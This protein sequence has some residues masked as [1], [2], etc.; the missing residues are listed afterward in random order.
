MFP[1]IQVD[2]DSRRS[3]SMGTKVKFW[4]EYAGEAHL[5]KYPRLDSGED[6]SEKVAAEIAD[7]LGLPHAEYELAIA[8][9]MSATISRK[10]HPDY[11]ELIT[12]DVLLRELVEDYP[13]PGTISNFKLSKH[14]VSAVLETLVSLKVQLPVRWTPPPGIT[15]APEVF[16]G[17][18]MLDALIGN[19]DRHHEN[20]GVVTDTPQ[21]GSPGVRHLAPTFDHASSLGCHESESSKSARLTTKDRNFTVEKY[22]ERARSRLY[23][24]SAD[25]KPLLTIRAFDLAAEKYQKAAR[26]WLARLAALEVGE[27]VKIMKR[28]P[29]DRI[30]EGS[31]QFASEILRHNRLRLLN[32]LSDLP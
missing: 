20:W 32:L 12:G 24:D 1:I 10:F 2:S 13:T 31:R 6:W 30:T 8:E 15:E 21:P 19:T 11:L 3:E 26:V 9:S 17:Y 7:L 27:L 29:R 18:L 5:V 23:A 4:V 28:V 16:V 25:D 22:C 14:T